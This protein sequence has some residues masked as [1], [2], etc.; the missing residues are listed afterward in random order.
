M[1][2]EPLWK[3]YEVM[4]LEAMEQSDRFLVPGNSNNQVAHVYAQQ[5]Q[6]YATLALVHRNQSE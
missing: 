5:A 2:E 1:A 6:V 4:A 3:R